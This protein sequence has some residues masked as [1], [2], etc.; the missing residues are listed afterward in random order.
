METEL[1]HEKTTFEFLNYTLPTKQTQILKNDQV[2]FLTNNTAFT[3]LK[4]TIAAIT[5]QQKTF[6]MEKFVISVNSCS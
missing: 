2:Y 6:L 5:T 4:V 3:W 1:K